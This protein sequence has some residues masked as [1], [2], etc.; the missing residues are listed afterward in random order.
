MRKKKMIT[1]VSEDVRVK[2]ENCTLV[3]TM[4]KR[5]YLKNLKLTIKNPNF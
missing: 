5:K 3:T 1:L 4:A 2:P